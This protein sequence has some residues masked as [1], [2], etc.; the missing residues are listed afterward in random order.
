MPIASVLVL[1]VVQGLTEFLPVSS[2]T[3][4]LFAQV[5]LGHEPDLALTVVL[6][7]GSLLAI[8]AYYGKAWLVLFRE[9]RKEILL[10]FVATLP[11]AAAALLLKGHLEALY[12]SPAL[13][14]GLLLVTGAWLVLAER[15]GRERHELDGAPLRK[16]LLVG[17]AQA[18]ALLP[19]ISRSGSTIGMGYLVGLRRQDA[20]RF[21]FFMGAVAIFGALLLMGRDIAR[22]QAAL[23]P[24]PILLGVLVTFAVSLAAIKLVES[25]SLKGRLSWFAAY[26]GVAGVAGLVYFGSRG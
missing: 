22:S 26:C 7:A 14:A 6:H 4:L 11:A 2:K 9:R 16:I 23:A 18:F 8:L 19:G 17:V 1:A 20:V 5:L 24:V 12:R 10:L 25:L 15:L 21:S 3:H 13:G